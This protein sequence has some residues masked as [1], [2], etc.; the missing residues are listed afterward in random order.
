[1]IANVAGELH[2]SHEHVLQAVAEGTPAL[3]TIVAGILARL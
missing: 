1:M 2:D 3:A